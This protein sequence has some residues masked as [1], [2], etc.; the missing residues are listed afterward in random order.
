LPHP[1]R[2]VLFDLDNTLADREAAFSGW[3]RWLARAH[4]GLT[5]GETIEEVVAALVVLD[6]DGHLP[7]EAFF[8]SVKTLYPSLDV[9][10]PKLIEDFRSELSAHL[11][12]LDGAAATL[13]AVLDTAGIPW[14]IVTNGSSQ[15][16]RRKIRHLGL[17]TRAGC[18]LIS[19]EVGLRKPDAAIFRLAAAH[20]GTP[21][22]EVLFVGDH[23]EA[24]V[25]GAANAGM[26]TAWTRRN[27]SWPADLAIAP[28]Y[29][30][31]SLDELCAVFL[32]PSPP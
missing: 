12:P 23:P 6:D 24:D 2:A 19:E 26:Q 5:D 10:V 14:G 32:S 27:R 13:L 3:C 29:Q 16:Q 18:M 1:I 22:H 21:V 4:L 31:A 9:E 20:L 17:E 28:G 11:P 30:I 7:R 15:N 25:V 8:Q